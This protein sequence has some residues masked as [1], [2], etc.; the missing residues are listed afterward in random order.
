MTAQMIDLVQ[1]DMNYIADDAASESGP[2]P[3]NT[4]PAEQNLKA[5]FLLSK[6]YCIL[7][8]PYNL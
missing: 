2:I 1:S 4:I 8:H 6:K 5:S 3:P 7:L